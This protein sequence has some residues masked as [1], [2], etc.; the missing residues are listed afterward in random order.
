MK[1]TIKILSLICLTFLAFSCSKDKSPADSDIFVGTYN[2]SVGY[3]N[4]DKNVTSDNS[5]VTVI[6]AGNNYNFKFNESGI[7]NLT[8]VEFKK[9]GDEQIVNIDLQD[10]VKVIRVTASKLNILYMKD[11]ETWTANATR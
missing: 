11:G 10:G 2:G 7:P 6:K 9:D 3:S 5:S 1:N 4:G 8:G